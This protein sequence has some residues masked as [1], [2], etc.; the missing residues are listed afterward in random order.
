[1]IY[2][3]YTDGGSREHN[4][5]GNAGGWGVWIEG[6][7]VPFGL[8]GS[9][10]IPCTNNMAEMMAYI[11]ALKKVIE[12]EP[13]EVTF[14]LDS[15]YVLKNCTHILEGW[16]RNGWLTSKGE[17]VKN[18]GLWKAIDEQQQLLR[19]Y[20]NIT[21]NYQWV[22]GHSGI[23]GN[24]C[25]DSLATAGL[26]LAR[27]GTPYGEVIE[28]KEHFYEDPN[29]KKEEAKED[30]KPKAKVKIPP[31]NAFLCFSR[32]L[33]ISHRPQATTADG[34]TI[35][36]AQQFSTRAK[37]GDEADVSTKAKK[38]EAKT[39]NLGMIDPDASE[40]VIVSKVP[41]P[42]YQRLRDYQNEVAPPV[43]D[44]P[45]IIAWDAFSSKARWEEICQSEKLPFT[46][47]NK[48]VFY[49]DKTTQLTYYLEVPRLAQNSVESCMSKLQ[50][51]EA[52][53][54]GKFDGDIEDITDMFFTEDKKGKTVLKK[55]TEFDR[56]ILHETDYEGKPITVRLTQKMH[57]PEV[58]ALHRM[59][60][61][62]GEMKVYFVKFI[63]TP[64]S[65]RHAIIVVGKDNI[66]MYNSPFS[67]LRLVP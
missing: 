41:C 36:M 33:D 66:G 43:A 32:I 38:A 25:A 59:Y 12:R 64:V 19:N 40:G 11:Q 18:I 53:E 34:R 42:Q 55:T 58:T 21:V 52:F 29:A 24:E 9:G 54:Q 65:F 37:S 61:Q 2:K 20:D 6:D 10:G 51:I 14:F 5:S 1:M 16:K 7:D 45:F 3:V 17:P 4:A 27:E 50:M 39:R 56:V 15:Q 8:Y 13:D 26:E 22:K 35:Y 49:K 30:K 23:L 47:S 63:K 62:E 60:K 67:S 44:F 46:K 57:M 28:T 48:S 31:S